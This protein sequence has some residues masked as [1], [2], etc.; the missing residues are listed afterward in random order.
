[1]ERVVFAE[2][3]DRRGHVRQRVRVANLPFSI[4]RGYQ[5]DLILDDPYVSPRHAQLERDEDGSLRLRDLDSLNGLVR[6]GERPS[7]LCVEGGK[8]V[9]LGHTTLRF[10][11]ADA[12]LEPT[13][14]DRP[15][16]NV[17]EWLG[18]HWIAPLAMLAAVAGV[19][20]LA[21]L[22]AS[23]QPLEWADLAS[24]SLTNIM[25][26]GLWAGFWALIT[27]VLSHRSRFLAHWMLAG[28]YS[29]VD[30]GLG[31]AGTY[32]RFLFAPILPVELFELV[33]GFCVVMGL[34]YGHLTLTGM[35]QVPRKAIL[36][37]ALSAAFL[38]VSQLD[39]LA[40]RPD[41]TQVL[42]YWS[43]LQPV[44]P[45]WLPTESPEAFF[46]GARDLRDEL[47]HLAGRQRAARRPE[48]GEER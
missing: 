25:L 35:T 1:M 11:D 15:E 41:W 33:S 20:V 8:S 14:V 12:A 32:A 9:R 38:S 3:L 10:P 46:R 2:V 30:E 39:T 7:E 36:A 6:G 26:L 43:R 24:A 31:W 48:A 23:Y 27:R 47:D 19:T 18:T 28:C 40:R 16:S 44:D 45:S 37:A 21:E 4:G 13:L 29:L 17:S 42:P 5:N 22:R 34:L